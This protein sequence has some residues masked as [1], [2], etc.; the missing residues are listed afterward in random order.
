LIVTFL[1]AA[2]ALVA[3]PPNENTKAPAQ[4]TLIALPILPLVIVDLS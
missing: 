3:Y 1:A 2:F 4:I